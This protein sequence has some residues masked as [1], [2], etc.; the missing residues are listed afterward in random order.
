MAR[1][2]REKRFKNRI[3]AHEFQTDN[4]LWNGRFCYEILLGHA[5]TVLYL[6]NT[7]YGTVFNMIYEL[8]VSFIT[9]IS[10]NNFRD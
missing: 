8:N 2:T 3:S 4:L 6:Y 9:G 10:Y 7:I 1:A 5:H